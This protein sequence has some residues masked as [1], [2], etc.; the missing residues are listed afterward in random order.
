MWR[1]VAALSMALLVACGGRASRG[2]APAEPAQRPDPHTQSTPE[3]AE[4]AQPKPGERVRQPVLD[5]HCDE[6]SSPVAFYYHG[7]R[8]FSQRALNDR[9]HPL[10]L[11]ECTANGTCTESRE[12][13]TG[14]WCCADPTQRTTHA[15]RAEHR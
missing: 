3:L 8:T 10:Y 4:G 7:G 6:G 12:Q 2:A 9:C 11:T 14:M 13:E 1:F 5:E 15:E